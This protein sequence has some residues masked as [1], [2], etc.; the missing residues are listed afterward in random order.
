MLSGN[1]NDNGIKFAPLR[2]MDS[3]GI[4]KGYFRQVFT[5]ISNRLFSKLD[6]SEVVSQINLP[7]SSD[8]AIEHTQVIVI[9]GLDNSVTLSVYAFT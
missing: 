6:K 2:F 5:L 1:R 9:T 3:N 4:G 8:V 7:Y